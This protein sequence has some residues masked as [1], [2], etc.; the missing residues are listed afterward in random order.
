MVSAARR[1]IIGGG[2]AP[3]NK[4]RRRRHKLSAT[5]AARRGLRTA[6]FEW[7]FRNSEIT[8]TITHRF[9]FRAEVPDLNRQF[10]LLLF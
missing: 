5:A 7:R 8:I 3:I 2:G 4:S 10:N 1:Q 6:L 9:Q